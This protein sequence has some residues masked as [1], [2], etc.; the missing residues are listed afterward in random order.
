MLPYDNLYRNSQ[1]SETL[2]KETASRC[3]CAKI[4]SLKLLNSFLH[5]KGVISY[6]FLNAALSPLWNLGQMVRGREDDTP[7]AA[8][9]RAVKS[10]RTDSS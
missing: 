6:D 3:S 9:I 5:P 8:L 10:P 1:R 2:I 4:F 7:E